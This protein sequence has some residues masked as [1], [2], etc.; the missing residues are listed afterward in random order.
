MATNSTQM[1]SKSEAKTGAQRKLID[2][3]KPI[4]TQY[5]TQ[6]VPG[7]VWNFRRVRYRMPEYEDHPSQKPES[8]IERIVLASSDAG[9]TV[10]DPFA[11]TFTTADCCEA[12]RKRVDK[13]RKP[14][15]VLES[16][17]S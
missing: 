8:L 2:Y 3:R 1:Q 9:D 13:H 10:L 17:P 12:I 11:G 4:P 14:R 16:G 6:K 7:N 15:E 5:N